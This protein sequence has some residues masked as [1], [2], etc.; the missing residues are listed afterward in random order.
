MTQR[1]L[2]ARPAAGTWLGSRRRYL[3]A[4]IVAL[5]LVV[6]TV[7]RFAPQPP[8]LA[9]AERGATEPA[10]PA[11]E[12][13]AAAADI[14]AA[15]APDDAAEPEAAAIVLE[16]ASD[17]ALFGFAPITDRVAPVARPAVVK[18]LYLNAWA[19]GSSRK[20]DRLIGIPVAM[21]TDSWT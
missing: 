16:G 21:P 8:E 15:A 13:A 12:A 20:L 7:A 1:D 4:G 9:V 2:D 18:G 3:A 11:A 14:E 6:F 19:A 10:A 17:D 5:V